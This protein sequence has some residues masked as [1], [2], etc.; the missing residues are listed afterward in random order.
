MEFPAQIP[1]GTLRHEGGRLFVFE[2]DWSEDSIEAAPDN[3]VWIFGCNVA[4]SGL[5]GQAC[6][7]RHPRAIGVATKKSPRRTHAAYFNDEEY[8]ENKALITKD[9]AVIARAVGAGYG[10]VLSDQLYGSG[11]ARLHEQAPFTFLWLCTKFNALRAYLK[12]ES[13]A[14]KEV[15]EEEVMSENERLYQM[16]RTERLKKRSDLLVTTKPKRRKRVRDQAQC[17]LFGPEPEAEMNREGF[18]SL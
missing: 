2:G 11:L 9:L 1:G 5:G 3:L 7:R 10:V 14:K 8:H 4:R 15:A 12:G 17:A 13:I 6:I 16:N 18:Q